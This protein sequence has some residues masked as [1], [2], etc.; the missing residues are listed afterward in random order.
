M[1]EA[2]GLQ[3]YPQK[4]VRQLDPPKPT[5][6]TFS[7]A[8]WSPRGYSFAKS[9]QPLKRSEAR[10]LL[11]LAASDP[12]D[13]MNVLR[14]PHGRKPELNGKAMAPAAS[15]HTREMLKCGMCVAC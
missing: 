2:L 14:R 1:D 8:G 12:D 11:V 3:L 4:V 10:I 5:P 9:A 7:G 15:G 6:T 13:Q